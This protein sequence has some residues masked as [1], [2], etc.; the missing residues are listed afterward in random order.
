MAKKQLTIKNSLASPENINLS[1]RL[2]ESLKRR[3][4]VS[5]D[6][7]G[8]GVR[9]RS[10]WFRQAIIA[11]SRD[12]KKSPEIFLSSL[13]LYEND[14]PGEMMLIRLS[15]DA[16]QAFLY[17]EKTAKPQF[18]EQTGLRTKVVYMSAHI[19]LLKEGLADI[20]EAI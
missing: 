10:E 2:S 5:M 14:D 17:L 15:G 20:P 13:M 6:L 4:T 3:I 7:R 18:R 8:M 11:L 12:A 19:Q 16:A 9:K 1:I